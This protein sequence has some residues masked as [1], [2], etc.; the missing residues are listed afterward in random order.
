MTRLVSTD[1]EIFVVVNVAIVL[2]IDEERSRDTVVIEIVNKFLS[3]LVRAIV[4]GDGKR[5]GD[6]AT[7][8]WND[9]EC[10]TIWT[11][12]NTET[13]AWFEVVAAQVRVV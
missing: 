1:Q 3:V 13:G 10:S 6:R 8:D 2:T 4:K 7:V 12:S 11:Y 5:V 9:R